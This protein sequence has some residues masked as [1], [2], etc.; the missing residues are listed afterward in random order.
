M[1]V[2]LLI[3]IACVLLFGKEETKGGI[4]SL[5]GVIVM[6]GIIAMIANA[7]GLLD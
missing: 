6:L 3:I 1:V 7:C 2:I 5:I 4:A